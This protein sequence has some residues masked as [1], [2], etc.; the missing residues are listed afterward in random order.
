MRS[1]NNDDGDGKREHNPLFNFIF[2]LS[3]SFARAS[4]FLV[5]FLPPMLDHDVK[6]PDF[7]F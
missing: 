7:T 5:H 2:L 4:H 3:S 1:L 6:P